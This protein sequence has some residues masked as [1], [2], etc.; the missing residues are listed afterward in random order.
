MMVT[1][2]Q[3]ADHCHDIS[4]NSRE[5]EIKRKNEQRYSVSELFSGSY[6]HL[7]G[8]FRMRL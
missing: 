3:Y 8:I 1:F 4:M 6:F 7:I 2:F 5:F